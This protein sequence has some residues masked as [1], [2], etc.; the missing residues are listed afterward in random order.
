MK[1]ALVITAALS[2]LV[3][4][5]CANR[6][7]VAPSQNSSLQTLS[8]STTTA[9]E[10]GIMQRSLDAW[11]KDEWTP[12]STPSAPSQTPSSTTENPHTSG[13]SE[14]AAA[15]EAE[16]NEPF[17]LQ[18]YVDKWK[19]YH[20]NKAKMK[21]GRAQEPSHVEMMNNLPVVGE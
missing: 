17:T 3:L 12:M 16:K 13:A 6:E 18:K 5:G 11:L 10:G 15:P 7:G 14:T 1:A 8:P 21:E 4:V 9:S 2:A 19:V 20:E